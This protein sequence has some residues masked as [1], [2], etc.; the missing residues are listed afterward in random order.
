M[1]GIAVLA[2]PGA[3]ERRLVRMLEAQRHRGPDA[4]GVWRSERAPLWLG[5]RR[6]RIIDLSSAANQ[7]MRS[8]DGRFV[9]VFN[10][11]I[12]NYR[13]LREELGDYPYRSESDSEV[14]LAAF[15]R[16]GDECLDRLIGMFAFV[17]W[18]E[19][20]ARLF[21]ARDR[22][23]VKPLY[24]AEQG[25]TLALASE[26]KA[27][28]CAGVAAAPDDRAWADF[29]AHGSYADSDGTFWR[30]IRQ[31]SPGHYLIREGEL[32]ELRRWY[33]L[34]SRVGA[35][36][37]ARD[38]AAVRDEYLGLLETSVRLRFRA[39]V[40]VGVN[41][42][43]GLDSATLLAAIARVQGEGASL[44][45]FTFVTG[46]PRYDEL[47]FAREL[48]ART[49]HRSEVCSLSPAEVPA[50]AAA[51]QQLEDEPYGGLPTLA[52]A[53][54]FERARELG[55]IVLLDGQGMDEQWAGYDYYRDPGY[56]AARPTLQAAGDAPL[57][58]DALASDFRALAVSPALESPFPDRLR[59]LQYR[60]LCRTKLPRALRFNDRI[61]MRASTE[62][63]EPF[64]D[65]RLVELALR[66]PASRKI[67][68]DVG[69]A[70]LRELV[71]DE[72]GWKLANAP[73]RALQT[74]QREWLR[75]ALRP[76][77][78]ALIDAL[79]RGPQRHWFRPEA[80][81]N[82]WQR[83]VAGA[84]ENS[85]FVWQWLSLAMLQERFAA[86]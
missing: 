25:A 80:V 32:T 68:G 67:R 10:G 18:D 15:A 11:E 37:D 70:F 84:G 35:Q 38:D 71:V 13:E 29:F 51:A 14:L 43:G 8:A 28:H 83:F 17:V 54:L 78:E 50:L 16:W 86:H 55:V 64:L 26:I 19:A 65:H 46:D 66:Q 49:R 40:E 57:R 61:S 6:L 48:L 59:N 74:P 2:G 20:R 60:D 22:F 76:W 42:S 73:K 1:C 77:A 3:N 24:Y 47:P 33:D 75:G 44:R 85:F 58:P 69:K 53:R 12:Y 41:L 36:E 56:Q 27:L 39:D 72:L 31:L 7:P 79:L 34:A 52:Y 4:E 45:A 81:R 21:A 5:H 62:L 23:G 9:L 30:G 82:E 63:R